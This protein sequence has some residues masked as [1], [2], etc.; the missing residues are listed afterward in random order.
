[1]GII[2]TL[3]LTTQRLSYKHHTF[4]HLSTSNSQTAYEIALFLESGEYYKSEC[5][6]YQWWD[7]KTQEYDKPCGMCI[8][9]C[10]V[11]RPRLI[12]AQ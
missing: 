3:S 1:M 10:S 9:L 8:K 2:D 12:P 6:H 4:A 11:G 5:A 7:R